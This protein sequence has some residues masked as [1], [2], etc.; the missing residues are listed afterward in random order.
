MTQTDGKREDLRVRRTRKML[1]ESLIALSTDHGFATVTVQE[2]ADHAMVNRATF[3][4]HYLDKY[5]LLD[6]YMEEV[7]LLTEAQEP[8]GEQDGP[9]AGLVH[10]LEHMQE[11]RDF[12]RAML[13]AKGDPTFALRIKAYIE[14]R[15]RSTLSMAVSGPPTP[16]LEMYV[17]SA[18]YS[19]VGAIVWWLEHGQAHSAETVAMWINQLN[20]AQLHAVLAAAP[21]R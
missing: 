16:L 19:G 17:S 10:L 8:R 4:R 12:Y 20:A 13:G 6:Q 3:Y 9:P 21:D 2:I 1:K 15:L 5:D 14:K 11:K 7:Y 18:A